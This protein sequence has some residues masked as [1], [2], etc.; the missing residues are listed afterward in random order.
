MTKLF[1]TVFTHLL[2]IATVLRLFFSLSSSEQTQASWQIGIAVV[3]MI[4]VGAIIWE[5]Y[6][7]LS[8]SP[9]RYRFFKQRR[10]K[11]Y[12]RRW[13]TS[14]GRAV[15]FT[16]DMTWADDDIATQDVLREKAR[17]HELIICIEKMIPFAQELER[18]GANVI[19]YGELDIVPRARYT[20]VDFQSDSARV[21]VGGAV[22]KV[23]VIQEFRNGEHPFFGVADDLARI[24]I[25]YKRRANAAAG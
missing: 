8:S 3:C 1:T 25:A 18:E 7:Y 19:S 4:L 16:R 20:I 9:V 10:I 12:M 11:S 22:G 21:A 17:R 23:H 5:I 2:A 14:G 15:I 13:L 6:G 24:L